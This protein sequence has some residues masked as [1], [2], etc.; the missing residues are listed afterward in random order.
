MMTTVEQLQMNSEPNVVAMET[1][2]T[3]SEVLDLDGE[4]LYILT[5][6]SSSFRNPLIL[7]TMVLT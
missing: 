1:E 7:T 3:S 4:S 5:S 6:F 2:V